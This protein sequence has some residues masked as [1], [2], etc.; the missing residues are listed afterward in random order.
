[1]FF[2]LVLGLALGAASAQTPAASLPAARSLFKQ[3]KF[4]EAAVAYK[5][6]VEKDKTS[7]SA[8]AG[9]VQSYLKAD[10]VELADQSSAEALAAL[11]QSALA[12]ALRGD[13]YFRKG[14]FSEAESEYRS[15]SKLDSRCARAWLGI[16]MIYTIVSKTGPA[17]DAF[18]K[19]RELDA[20]DG[21]ILYEWAIR[22]P[23]PENVRN[24]EAYVAE[25]HF[26]PEEERRKREY[27]DFV[28]AIAGHDI[29]IQSKDIPHSELKLEPIIPGPGKT[30]GWSV[31]INLNGTPAKLWL[32]TGASWLTISR[33]LANKIGAR[34]L[35]E[36]A[37]EGTG[38]GKATKSYLAWVDK[39][40]IGDIEFHD[41][42]VHVSEQRFLEGTDG[43]TGTSFFSRNLVT[44][45]FPRQRLI[46]AP[47]PAPT[48]GASGPEV[49]SF[50]PGSNSPT[51]MFSFGHL[52]VVNTRIDHKAMGLFVLDTG[53]NSSILSQRMAAEIGKAH[54]LKKELAGMSGVGSSTLAERVVLQFSPTEQPAQDLFTSSLSSISANLGTEIS[55]MIGI[56]TL[57]RMKIT[58]N[59]RDGWIEFNESK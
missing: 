9:L 16:G 58:I 24:L 44:F 17:K 46:V 14:L 5:A 59:Y 53:S 55:G 27:L 52:P 1:M 25:F 7:S 20:E 30:L 8:Y 54:G 39:V 38:E 32:D 21:D 42:I 47:L 3:G 35:S 11:P 43:L 34:K 4:Q 50:P 45:D 15:A 56:T 51:Q 12:H 29:W 37:Q 13:V 36:Q 41:C 26:A 49:H 23:Y 22:L 28:R 18:A 57:N 2:L 33:K 48:D 31:A 10:E 40:T 6:I 19:A